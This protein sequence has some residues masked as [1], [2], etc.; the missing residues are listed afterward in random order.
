M[1][2]GL[3]AWGLGST[4]VAGFDTS[5]AL[6]WN[7]FLLFPGLPHPLSQS[8]PRFLNQIYDVVFPSV[9]CE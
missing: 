3:C 9:Y 6:T 1:A 4:A 2:S 8:L 7:A 5:C